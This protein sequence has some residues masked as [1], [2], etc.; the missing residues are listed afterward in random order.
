MNTDA[1]RGPRAGRQRGSLPG[2]G[3]FPVR[4]TICGGTY[5]LATGL[6]RFVALEQRDQHTRRVRYPGRARLEAWRDDL[7]VVPVSLDPTAV[8][9]AFD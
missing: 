1:R 2:R 5:N 7:C 3:L 6:K 8:R 9:L 4:D